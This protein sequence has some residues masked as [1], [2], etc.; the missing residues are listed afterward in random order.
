MSGMAPALYGTAI[1][2]PLPEDAVRQQEKEQAL[3]DAAPA[4][5]RARSTLAS[6]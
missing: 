4:P 6:A 2:L 1:P 3:L 5:W